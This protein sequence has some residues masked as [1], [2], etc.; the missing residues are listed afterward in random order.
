MALS[1]ADMAKD[2]DDLGPGHCDAAVDTRK[3]RES[4]A[5]HQR[6]NR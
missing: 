2:R 3:A 6:R 4:L 1:L 5:R